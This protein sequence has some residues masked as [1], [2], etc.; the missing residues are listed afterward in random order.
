MVVLLNKSGDD[1]VLNSVRKKITVSLIA[2][3]FVCIL[4]LSGI[5]IYEIRNSVLSQM[6]DDGSTIATITTNDI[7]KYGV[8][9]TGDI[10]ELVE[11]IQKT[12]KNRIQYIYVTDDK[13]TIIAH[14]DILSANKKV[15]DP[16]LKDVISKSQNAAFEDVTKDGKHIYSVSA[17]ILDGSS[18]VGMLTIGLSLSNMDSLVEKTMIYEVIAAIILLLLCIPFGMFISGKIANPL[19]KM[20][21][22]LDEVSNGNFNVNFECKGNDE[23][24]KLGQTLNKTIE[25][26][27]GIIKDI[28]TASKNIDDLSTGLY[29]NQQS[30]A[31][32]SME[33][34]ESINLIAGEVM[35]QSENVDEVHEMINRLSTSLDVI[36]NKLANVSDSSLNIKNT[37]DGGST[38]L[39]ELISSIEDIRKAFVSVSKKIEAL[40]LDVGKIN[41]ITEA[42]NNVASQTNLLALNAAIEAARAGESGRGF[43]VVA[44]EIGKLAEEVIQSSKGISSLVSNITEATKDVSKTSKGVENKMENQVDV[45]NATVASFKGILEEVDATLPYVDE[46]NDTINKSLDEKQNLSDKISHVAS[47]AQSI[48]ASAQQISAS[49]E[50]QVATSESLSTK[51]EEL[52]QMSGN[53]SKSVEEYVV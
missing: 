35:E 1:R 37:A 36:N 33:V 44:D 27:K 9:N 34:S 24:G 46:A 11:G 21:K 17:P 29:A 51:V 25:V 30:T 48:S 13:M 3:T 4:L 32:S 6:K 43:S 20:M 5:S 38:K 18:T 16:R 22:S 19:R 28:K 2:V 47:V 53:L 52:S 41:E 50:E 10:Q 14:N 45:I 49:V 31:S 12:S 26:T 42:I 40:A 39:E 15:T 7:S 23:I 8:S